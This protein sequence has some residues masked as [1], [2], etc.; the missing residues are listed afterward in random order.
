MGDIGFLLKGL[1]IGLAVAAPVGP[2]GL[3]C[4]RRSL[5][6]GR[7]AGFVTGLGAAAA[8]GLYGFVAAFGVTTI[9]SFMTGNAELFRLFGGLFLI[10]LG[11]KITLRPAEPPAGEIAVDAGSLARDWFTTFMLTLANPTTILSFIGIFA[12]VGIAEADRGTIAGTWLVVGIFLGSAA[13]WLALALGVGTFG[14]RLAAERMR[15]VNMVGGLA[16]VGFG[17]WALATL[18]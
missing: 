13:W 3:L 6:A 7:L 2:I 1:A 16:I 4:I 9:A 15:H 18:I 17:V 5:E 12:A 10:G 11:V 14:R 8:D